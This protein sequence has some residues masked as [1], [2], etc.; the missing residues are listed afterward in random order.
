MN[1]I[2][3]INQNGIRISSREVAEM[4]EIEHKNLI[5]K[6]DNINKDFDSAKLSYQK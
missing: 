4:M 6:I 2:Q 5:R 1:E 3:K